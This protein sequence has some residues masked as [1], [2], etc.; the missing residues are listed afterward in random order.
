[1]LDNPDDV[2][3]LGAH[4]SFRP[5]VVVQAKEVGRVVSLLQG[6]ETVEVGPEGAANHS[7][8]V[9]IQS[10]EVQVFGA[11]GERLQRAERRATPFEGRAVVLWAFPVGLDAEQEGRGAV[12][13]AVSKGPIRLNAPPSCQISSVECGVGLR[14]FKSTRAVI[15]SSGKLAR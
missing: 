6:D 11:R 3:V 10:W 13:K 7:V 14:S 15:A 12:P 5:D 8:I 9:L 1:M 2:V 4:R